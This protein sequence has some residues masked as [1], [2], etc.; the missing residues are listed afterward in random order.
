MNYITPP[1]ATETNVETE[2]IRKMMSELVQSVEVSQKSVLHRRA[3]MNHASES[4][5]KVT[6][7]FIDQ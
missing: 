1:L 7:V 5:K 2:N 6:Q 3:E 4:N